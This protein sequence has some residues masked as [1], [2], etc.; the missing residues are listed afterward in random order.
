[1]NM[2][3][4]VNNINT[5]L[6]NAQP[7]VTVDCCIYKV[8]F[9]IRTLNDNAYTPK[10]ISIGPFHHRHHRLQNMERHKH[11]YFKA[12]LQRTD[13]NLHTFIP[14]IQS[15]IPNFNRSYSET[16]DFTDQELVQLILIDSGFIIELFWRFFYD[17]WSQADALVLKPWL[18]SNIRLDLLLLENQLPFFVIEKIFNLSNSS[19]ASVNT[20]IPSFIELTFDYFAYYNTSNLGCS[21]IS[22]SHFTDLI[23][24]FHLQ[25]PLDRRPRRI[26]EPMKH[27]P[28][29]TELLEAGVRFKVNTESQCLLDLRF[30]GRVLEIPQLK[31]EDWTEILFRNMVAL[32]QCHYPYE[33]YI[34]DYVAVLDFLVNTGKDVDILVG[35]KILVNW[36]GDSDSVANLFNSLWKNVT[37]S[38]FSSDYSVL[39][40]DL[41]GFCSDPWHKLKATLRR[42]YCNTPWQM[43]ASIAAILILVLTLLQSVCSVLQVVQH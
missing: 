43:A 11:I 1:M 33:S 13:A 12:F 18:A 6:N 42:D 22:I 24:I 38:N 14:Y 17:D 23:R 10:L 35:K 16:L 26:D 37:H 27:L 9:S 4:M 21:G 15:I 34:T 3:D 40:E 20:K 7:P 8:P 19:H 29:V 25:H 30:S 28:S 2:D 36:L 31:V 5:I 39:C 32:E 41:N